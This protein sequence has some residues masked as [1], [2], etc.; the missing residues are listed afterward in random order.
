M[1]RER[2][3][4][5]PSPGLSTSAEP[6]MPLCGK[7]LATADGEM[8]EANG[9]DQTASP[10]AGRVRCAVTCLFALVAA[11]LV[12][13]SC[14]ELYD[15]SADAE[16][17]IGILYP[18]GTDTLQAAERDTVLLKRWEGSPELSKICAACEEAADTFGGVF[19][20]PYGDT[21]RIAWEIP[22]DMYGDSCRLTVHWR[23]DSSLFTEASRVSEVFVILEPEPHISADLYYYGEQAIGDTMRLYWTSYGGTNQYVDITLRDSSST[24]VRDIATGAPDTGRCVWI[25]DCAPGR[26]RIRIQRVADSLFTESWL[27]TFTE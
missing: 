5:A 24:W 11:L 20:F 27:I 25:I 4:D 9:A 26:Y 15:F 10:G 2:Q 23:D 6:G 21:G 14:I 1:S 18:K 19:S 13:L 12:V 17:E 16:S 8:D 7:S 22:P 3:N